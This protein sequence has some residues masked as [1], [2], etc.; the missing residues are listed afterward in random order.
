M[1]VVN[2]ISPSTIRSQHLKACSALL[3][4]TLNDGNND[5]IGVILMPMHTSKKNMMWVTE[6]SILN[7]LGENRMNFDTPFCLRFQPHQDVRDERPLLYNGRIACPMGSKMHRQM[8]KD[9]KI[10]K[11]NCTY[12]ATH[13]VAAN[14]VEMEERI[15]RLCHLYSVPLTHI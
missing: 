1:T 15:L 8:L 9:C 14:M 11:E 2:L 13:E 6:V 3:G 12:P 10:I 4:S 7:L 5:N